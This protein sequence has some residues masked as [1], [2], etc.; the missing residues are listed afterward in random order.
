MFF[1]SSSLCMEAFV[2]VMRTCDTHMQAIVLVV[3][4]HDTRMEL[5]AH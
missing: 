5:T 1:C 4:T 3:L 2:L